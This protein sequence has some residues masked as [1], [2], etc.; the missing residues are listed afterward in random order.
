MR[1]NIL[2]LAEEIIKNSFD[3]KKGNISYK[4]VDDS[5]IAVYDIRREDYFGATD[6]ITALEGA[7]I[8]QFINSDNGYIS[9]RIFV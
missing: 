8:P 5:A 9:L 7:N 3:Y 6:I 4:R 1:K 2:Y